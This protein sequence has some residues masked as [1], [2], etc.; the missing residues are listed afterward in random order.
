MKRQKMVGLATLSPPYE[1]K[2]MSE[3][4]KRDDGFEQK[5]SRLRMR[6][7]QLPP[8]QRPHLVELADAISRQHLHLEDK[9]SIVADSQ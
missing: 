4:M 3:E 1:E 6:I 5:L 8:E 9:K 7:D 2:N